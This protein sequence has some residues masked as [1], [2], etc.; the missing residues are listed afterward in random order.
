MTVSGG[1][2]NAAEARAMQATLA[3]GVSLKDGFSTRLQSVAGFDVGGEEDGEVVRAA[4]ALLDAVTLQPI[5]MRVAR[6]RPSTPYVPGLLGFREL[7]ALLAV[8]DLLPQRPDLAFVHG[9]G[10]A[11]PRRFGIA[12]HFG[13]AADLPT[14]GV[15]TTI[16]VG[17]GIIPHPMRG[18]YTALRDRGAQIGWLLRS[19]VDCDPLV[20]SPGHRVAMASAADLVMRFVGTD[21]L[22]E[23]MRLAGRLAADA[24]R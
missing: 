7:P 21:P 20:V 8:L 12:A 2:G 24:G 13:V 23:P 3:Q 5:A 15:A 9:H 17:D 11:H 1:N 18:A 16:L 10:I 6:V 22:P 14:I 19:K 4:A